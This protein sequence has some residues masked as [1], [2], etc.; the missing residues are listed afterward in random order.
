MSLRRPPGTQPINYL[1]INDAEFYKLV[2]DEIK[3][4]M[5]RVRA[6]RSL[7]QAQYN[8][9]LAEARGRLRYKYERIVL[10][11]LHFSQPWFRKNLQRDE[12]NDLLM[13]FSSCQF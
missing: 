1:F 10:K 4:H 8:Q 6:S 7:T 2:D 3:L 11:T 9:E 12:A 5:S 13:R